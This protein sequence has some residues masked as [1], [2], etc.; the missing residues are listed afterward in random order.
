MRE[1]YNHSWE[2][3]EDEVG[4]DAAEHMIAQAKAEPD[5]TEARWAYLLSEEW[6]VA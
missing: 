5:K 6:M 4:F 3:F 2:H 1:W